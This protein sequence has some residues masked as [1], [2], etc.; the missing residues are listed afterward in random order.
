M[1]TNNK[2]SCHLNLFNNPTCQGCKCSID[3]KYILNVMNTFWH[4]KCLNCFHCGKHLHQTCF[5]KNLEMYC[6]EDYFK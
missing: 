4:E 5:Y 1:K 3:D 2:N 6:R